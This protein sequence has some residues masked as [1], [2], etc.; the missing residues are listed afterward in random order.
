MTVAGAGGFVAALAVAVAVVLTSAAGV[1][2]FRAGLGAAALAAALMGGFVAAF[3]AA[4]AVVVRAAILVATPIA[5]FGGTESRLGW[6]HKLFADGWLRVDL[7]TQSTRREPRRTVATLRSQ[8]SMAGWRCHPATGSGCSNCPLP[9]QE[10]Q[11]VFSCPAACALPSTTGAVRRRSRPCQASQDLGACVG[12]DGVVR[13]NLARM[14]GRR[15]A[16]S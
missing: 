15:K 4:L 5:V 10:R 14:L 7:R 16:W 8:R 1:A 12:D 13:D 2:P 3:G 11:V 6:E 9:C